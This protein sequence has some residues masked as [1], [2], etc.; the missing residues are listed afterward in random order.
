MRQSTSTTPPPWARTASPNSLSPTLTTATRPGSSTGEPLSCSAMSELE[1]TA[2][3]EGGYRMRTE[4]RGLEVRADEPPEYRG[5]GA[6]EP[7]R[8]AARGPGGRRRADAHGAVPGLPRLVLRDGGRP[9]RAQT[10]H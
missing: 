10:G 4:V 3:W 7:T 9:R 1:L 6:R 5:G 8:R 2:H